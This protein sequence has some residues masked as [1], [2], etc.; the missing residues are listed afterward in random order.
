MEKKKSKSPA[1]CINDVLPHHLLTE[2]L[3]CLPSI[4][5]FRCTSVCKLWLSCLENDPDI[6]SRFILR[7]IKE[8]PSLNEKEL[9]YVE[10]NPSE[11]VMLT[12]TS[13]CVDDAQFSLDFLPIFDDLDLYGR[14]LSYTVVDSSNGLLLCMRSII[15]DERYCI[16]NPITKQWFELPKFTPC[17]QNRDVQ[18]G[19]FS[20]PFYHV[21]DDDDSSITINHEFAVKVVI[22]DL[23]RYND[24]DSVRDLDVEMFSSKTGCWTTS[25]LQLPDHV[26][27]KLDPFHH[28]PMVPYKRRL[29]WLVEE[30]YEFLIY[31]TDTDEFLMDRLELPSTA[32]LGPSG[33]D[34]D[35]V[36]FKGL[37]LCRGS[38]FV[39][40]GWG[41]RYRVHSLTDNGEWRLWYDIDFL[42]DAQCHSSLVTDFSTWMCH[43]HTD[44]YTMH[45]NDPTVGFVATEYM[46]LECNFGSRTVTVLI[47]YDKDE[48]S[49]RDRFYVLPVSLPIWPTPL[50]LLPDA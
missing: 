48:Y 3:V 28:G 37:S 14:S 15:N 31:D 13:Y 19:F 8:Q 41:P 32:L 21:D 43:D 4:D 26:T 20:D 38:L 50:P 30:G 27:V 7:R 29:Y 35:V 45:P 25:R 12:P 9:I 36:P 22:L 16:C 46:L 2:V 18:V 44:F 11:M 23:C 24:D 17:S 6:I 39:A 47:E 33:E 42:K 5:L 1:V 10:W 49:D 34:D 40:Q